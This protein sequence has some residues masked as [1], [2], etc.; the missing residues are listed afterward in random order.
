MGCGASVGEKEDPEITAKMKKMKKILKYME[1][2]K[3]LLIKLI[4]IFIKKL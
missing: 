3:K 4:A 1:N 2:D